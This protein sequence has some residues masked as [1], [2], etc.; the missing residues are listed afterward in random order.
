MCGFVTARLHAVDA[1]APLHAIDATSSAYAID[2]SGRNVTKIQ[3]AASHSPVRPAFTHD[4]V[5]I[6]S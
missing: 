1:T 5:L 4:E 2:A 3:D 6:Q